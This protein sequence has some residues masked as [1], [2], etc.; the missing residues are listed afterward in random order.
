MSRNTDFRKW[1][2]KHWPGLYVW[3]LKGQRGASANWIVAWVCGIPPGHACTYPADEDDYQRCLALVRAVPSILTSRMGLDTMG[4][5]W[6]PWIERLRRD[7]AEA[8]Q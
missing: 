3:L 2:D 1:A 8:L 5:G 6:Q 7:A 4:N